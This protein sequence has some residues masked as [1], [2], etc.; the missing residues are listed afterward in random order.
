MAIVKQSTFPALGA[1]G[2]PLVRLLSELPGYGDALEKT[3]GIHPEILAYKS[4]LEPEPGKTYVHILALGA[5]DFYGPN[6][7]N[8]HFPWQGLQH[9]HTKTPH[10]YLHGYKTFLNAHAFAHHMNKD[11]EKAYGDVLLSVLNVKMKRVELIVAIDEEKCIR[12][13]GAKTLERIKAGEYPSTSMGCRVPFDV[14]SICGHKAKFRSEYC[15]HMQNEAGKIYADGRRVFVYNPYPRFFD[16]SFVF[17]GAD[18]TSFVLEKVA[19]I[20]PLNG[21]GK[22]RASAP[23]TPEPNQVWW[24]HRP[25]FVSDHHDPRVRD[26]E[27]FVN[28]HTDLGNALFNKQ[29]IPEDSDPNLIAHGVTLL[30]EFVNLR[31]SMSMNRQAQA[32]AEQP[33]METSEPLGSTDPVDPR[34]A[35]TRWVDFYKNHNDA[36]HAV[37]YDREDAETADINPAL[38]AEG[39]RLYNLAA[40]AERQQQGI[41]DSAAPTPAPT[42]APAPAPA[43]HAPATPMPAAAA[44]AA[45]AAAPAPASTRGAGRLGSVIGNTALMLGTGLTAALSSGDGHRAAG[46]MR[47]L[48]GGMLLSPVMSAMGIPPAWRAAAALKGGSMLASGRGTPPPIW[49]Y[50]GAQPDEEQKHASAEAMMRRK[51]RKATGTVQPYVGIRIQHKV[52]PERRNMPTA[53]KVRMANRRA[54]REINNVALRAESSAYMNAGKARTLIEQNGGITMLPTADAAAPAEQLRKEAALKEAEVQKM[55]DIFKNVNSLPMGRAVR[56]LTNT[57]RDIPCPMLNRLAQ[58]PDL[59]QALGGL[60]AAGIV[61][62]PQEFQRVVLVRTGQSDLANQLMNAGQTFDPAGA[63]IARTL[64][65]QI[66]APS[67]GAIPNGLMSLISMLLRGRSALT[68]FG[69]RRDGDDEATVASPRITVIRMPVLDKI[70]ALYNGYREDLLLNADGLMKAASLTPAL[71]REITVVRGGEYGGDGVPPCALSE[72]P[73]A[74]FSHAYWNRCCC[75]RDLDDKAFARKF[76]DEN[77]EITK[78]LARVVAERYS[79]L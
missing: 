33:H 48:L 66:S 72:L 32:T 53:G 13:G 2:E 35:M 62:K 12:N 46:G 17:I 37:L 54:M 29:T 70:A 15:A 65:I 55:S 4:Q 79:T 21:G 78:Y 3:A 11:P 39:R 69:L 40:A 42:P 76:V 22:P 77:P 7:N 52:E 73:M 44:P 6:L 50:S 59:G 30:R 9:D 51:L 71:T 57:D 31:N 24:K 56:M 36:G 28:E 10:P 19:A 49:S 75:D 67:A 26:W 8:D 1:S 45:P 38:I 25:G 23:A 74:Y 27:N 58:E 18:R 34:E 14:C 64:R 63:P 41:E 47:G 60:G 5:G 43:A 68:P 61:L 20:D 16:I